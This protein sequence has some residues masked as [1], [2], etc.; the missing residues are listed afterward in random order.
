[1]RQREDS[2]LDDRSRG[3]GR[4]I[5]KDTLIIEPTSGNTGIGLAFVCAQRGYKLVLTM[6]ETMSI[7]RRAILRIFGA[8]IVLTEGPKGMQGAV[9]KAL[10]LK[11]GYPNSFIP[12]QFENEANPEI[13]RKTTAEEIWKD[14]T[15]RLTSLWQVSVRAA[16]L[17]SPARP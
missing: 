15:A 12:Q 1:L 2:S 11:K 3:E 9:D 10:E 13:H 16:R 4:Q 14:T 5:N 17:R 7:E 6:P 8:E